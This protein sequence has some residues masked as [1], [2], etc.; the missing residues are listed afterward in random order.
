[1]QKGQRQEQLV[2]LISIK[3]MLITILTNGAVCVV[4]RVQLQMSRQACN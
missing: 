2:S 3:L 1:V 4:Q